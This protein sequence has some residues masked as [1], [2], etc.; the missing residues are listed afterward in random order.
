MTYGSFSK[1]FDLIISLL[2]LQFHGDGLSVTRTLRPRWLAS[3][4]EK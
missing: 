1:L 2:S 3:E 4:E